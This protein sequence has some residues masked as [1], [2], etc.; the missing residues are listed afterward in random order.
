MD[1]T[2]VDALFGGGIATILITLV[3][4]AMSISSFGIMLAEGLTVR[5]D[6]LAAPHQYARSA[7]MPHLAEHLQDSVWGKIESEVQDLPDETGE[8]RELR[9][10]EI[11]ERYNGKSWGRLSFL[12]SI[13]ANAP[14]VGLF[15]TVV[16]V[17]GALT[18]IGK[19]SVLSAADIGPP[20]GEALVMTAFGLLV[21]VPAVFGYN[22]LTGAYRRRNQHIDI[23]VH[24]LAQPEASRVDLDIAGLAMAQKADRDV[25]RSVE[26]MRSD[27]HG[28][29]ATPVGSDAR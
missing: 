15:G 6:L 18:E 7:G 17:M 4:T 24:R 2:V 21:A 23:L 25:R 3:L 11:I 19:G 28:D 22:M 8:M 13:G 1:I 26:N 29:F 9:L 12:A 5:R 16:G 27:A 20:V 14:F 10:A